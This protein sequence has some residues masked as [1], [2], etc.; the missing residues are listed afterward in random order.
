MDSSAH[1]LVP[2]VIGRFVR[3]AD[4]SSGPAR[5]FCRLAPRG[6]TR[7]PTVGQHRWAAQASGAPTGRV[8]SMRC[9]RPKTL[10]RAA[11]ALGWASRAGKFLESGKGPGRARGS[12]ASLAEC[13][14]TTKSLRLQVVMIPA[15]PLVA[16]FKFRPFRSARLS[17]HRALSKV[18]P[19]SALSN[20]L[21]P[22]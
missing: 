9:T 21:P 2:H 8:L 20:R 3:F 7:W 12:S 19:F 11:L 4:R 10:N 18:P 22:F 17:E 13:S 16:W 1:C 14:T 15:D 6:R 5:R